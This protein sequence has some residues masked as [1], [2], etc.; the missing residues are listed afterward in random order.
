MIRV[1]TDD[2]LTARGRAQIEQPVRYGLALLYNT[3]AGEI[4]R[5]KARSV[6]E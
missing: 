1:E 4:Q 5:N 3:I 6:S 2:Y